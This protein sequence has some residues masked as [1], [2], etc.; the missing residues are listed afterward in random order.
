MPSQN[1]H[2]PY[3]ASIRNVISPFLLQVLIRNHH[4]S[5]LPTPIVSVPPHHSKNTPVIAD[6][7][8]FEPV[9][10]FSHVYG[11]DTHTD[12]FYIDMD[13]LDPPVEDIA[14]ETDVDEVE[15]ID[16][17]SGEEPYVDFS[18]EYKCCE[19]FHSLNTNVEN[20]FFSQKLYREPTRNETPTNSKWTQQTSSKRR[21]F[22]EPRVVLADP[23]KGVRF[24]FEL[25]F[26]EV[27][28]SDDDTFLITSTG[29]NRTRWNAHFNDCNNGVD[30]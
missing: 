25:P 21:V 8:Q 14:S 29:N 2:T 30:I 20:P 23:T 4:R 12:F 22:L 5:L 16:I 15:D 3:R 13:P 24:S 28:G 1:G 10:D 17:Y 11:S 18:V 9:L 6:T 27:D 19:T 26:V 7:T